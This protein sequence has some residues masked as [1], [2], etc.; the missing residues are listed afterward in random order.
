MR[1]KII[2]FFDSVVY[3][4]IVLIPFSIAIAPAPMNIFIGWLIASFL[5]KK[6]IAKQKLFINTTI[7]APFLC[8]FVIS[9]ISIVNS[10]NYQDSFRGL[11][12][13]IQYLFIFLILA[14]ELKDKVHIKRIFFS[15]VLG[16]S[17]VSI[18]ALW[19]LIFGKDFIRG[20]LP[21]INISIKRATASFPDANVLGIYLSALIPALFVLTLYYF[22]NKQKRIML[23]ISILG[24]LGL[25][26]TYSRPTIL[27]IYIIL[28]LL[29][30]V[31]KDKIL[32]SILIIATIFVPFVAPQSIKNWA[33][34]VDYHPM[35]FM[36]NDD[37]IAIYRNAL[38]MIKA[39]SLIGVGV[40]TFMKNYRK[41]K[42]SPEYRNIITSDY[43]Y[44]H[45][46]FLHIAAEIGIPGLGIF[47]WLIYRLFRKSVSIYNKL[48]DNFLKNISLGIFLCLIS[49]LINGLTESSL[50]YS[51]V[52]VIFWYLIGFSLA[53][54]KFIYANR[55]QSH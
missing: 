24:F 40:N 36:C 49:F 54:E 8:F 23:L 35:R 9:F 10:V 39:H 37:R 34:E 7:N 22:K 38:N 50:Y 41:Y 18:D 27:A 25:A 5:I 33:K 55:P 51:R 44:A 17:L 47:L 42:E 2:R 52:A 11:F 48:K 53:L 14:Q 31:K 12:R 21:I 28:L 30:M 16:I 43:M 29:G 3:T 26:L 1:E 4:M 15:M 32:L 20:H 45:N 6:I 19:Q 46:N 13:L